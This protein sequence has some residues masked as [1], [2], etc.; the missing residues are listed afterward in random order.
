VF[1][2]N[3]INILGFTQSLLHRKGLFLFV[4]WGMVSIF[5]KVKRF[6]FEA[7]FWLTGLVIL[8]TLEPGISHFSLCPLKNAGLDFCPGCGL[9]TSI[10]LF[11][12]GR[13]WESVTTHPLGIFAVIVLS[14]RIINLTKQY[15]RYGKSY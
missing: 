10:S 15:I 6:P 7:L 14:F 4:L 1:R 8:A 9:G 13:I 12:H 11:F 2:G 3:L 5:R